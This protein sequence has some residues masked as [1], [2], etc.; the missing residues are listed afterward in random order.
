MP[1]EALACEAYVKDITYVHITYIQSLTC[2]EMVTVDSNKT[3]LN[4]YMTK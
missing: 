3:T 4:N 2:K 1:C